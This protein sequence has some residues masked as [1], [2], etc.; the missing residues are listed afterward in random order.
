VSTI[1]EIQDSL[2]A[3]ITTK[4]CATSNPIIP[5]L[6]VN[7][8]QEP[9][10]SPPAID[11]YPGEDPFTEQIGFGLGQRSYNFTVRARVA[12]SDNESGQ[13]LLLAMMDDGSPESVEVAIWTVS[14][15]KSV[16]GPTPYRA[17]RDVG[18]QTEWL[19]CSWRVQFIP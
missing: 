6:Q 18:G 10:P 17:Y 8:R 1:A 7:R 11:V 16:I 4:L 14:G 5:E 3:G 9:N 13:D 12:T 2:A 19:G 15:V